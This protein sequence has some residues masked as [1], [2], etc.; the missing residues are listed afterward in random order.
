MRDTNLAAANNFNNLAISPLTVS[1]E[2]K[3]WP[4]V[5]GQGE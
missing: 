1:K 5:H 3:D 2:N 4:W